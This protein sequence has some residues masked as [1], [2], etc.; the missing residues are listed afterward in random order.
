MFT[1]HT[2]VLGGDPNRTIRFEASGEY[3]TCHLRAYY[4]DQVIGVMATDFFEA[5]CQIRETLTSQGLYPLCHGASLD[6]YAFGSSGRIHSGL[7]AHR[8]VMGRQVTEF[9]VVETFGCEAP[10]TPATVVEQRDYY[11]QWLESTA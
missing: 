7:L 5:L 11:S 10:I 9:D 1:F 8:L 4:R 2:M 3:A 6:V